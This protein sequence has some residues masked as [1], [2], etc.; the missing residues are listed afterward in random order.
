MPDPVT[1]ERAPTGVPGLDEVLEG[2]FPRRRV[3]LVQGDPGTGKTTLGL[4]FL[5]AGRRLGERCLYVTLSETRDELAEVAAS[6]GWS[7][8]GIDVYAV[9]EG[10]P[11]SE[12][13]ENT[14][15]LTSEV[16]LEETWRQ[17][18]ERLKAARP[19]RVVFDSLTE[20]RLLA[21]SPLRFRRQVFAL[22]WYLA[23]ARATVLLLEQTQDRQPNDDIESLAQSIIALRQRTPGYG[24]PRRRLE[25]VKMRASRY[26]GGF[27]DFEIETGGL[28]V[29]PRLVASEE[30]R[31][32]ESDASSSGIPELDTLA[33]GGIDRGTTVLILGPAGVGKSSLSMQYAYQSALRGELVVYFNFDEGIRT[34]QE[35][36][37]GLGMDLLAPGVANQIRVPELGP[38]DVSAGEFSQRIRTF[39][40]DEN[41]RMIVIDGLNGYLASV[42]EDRQ[43]LL[44]LHE[45]FAYLR[46]TSVITLLTIGQSG[47]LGNT[48]DSPID[49][50]YLADS[51]LLL[52]FYEARGKVRKAIS[53]IKRRNRGHETAIRDFQIGPERI[54][55]GPPLEEF[56]GILTGHPHL[57]PPG[58]PP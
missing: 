24:S 20:V 5:L 11:A 39:V 40:E 51:V 27:H 15:F 33:G 3:S 17:L 43:V 28:R 13:E 50:S 26:R 52:R 6:H 19:D 45:L 22:K 38:T 35:R 10:S 36:S 1:T 7:L 48:V 41:A 53:V 47:F 44:Q 12:D 23:E 2:G 56:Q 32:F 49:V 58:N 8:D 54:R 57:I 55:V 4:A 37:R 31:V 30:E 42:G 21:Q 34:L 29:F 16:E 18:L 25:V 9:P 46:R 14:L